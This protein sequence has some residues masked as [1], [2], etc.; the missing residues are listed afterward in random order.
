[1]TV[2][3]TLADNAFKHQITL[4][5]KTILSIIVF[6]PYIFNLSIDLKYNNIKFKK[7]FIDLRA[8]T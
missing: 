4:S 3:N 6:T 2:V 7:L 5:N 1:M 8:L